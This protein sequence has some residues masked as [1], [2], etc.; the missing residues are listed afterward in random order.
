[1]LAKANKKNPDGPSISEEQWAAF[2]STLRFAVAGKIVNV[3][4][5]GAENFRN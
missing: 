1:M 2:P 5:E 3:E 4:Q